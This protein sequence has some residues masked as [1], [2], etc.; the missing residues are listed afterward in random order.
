M[1]RRSS[2]TELR[3]AALLDNAS[4]ELS[5]HCTAC[6]MVQ[7]A[8][9]SR[10]AICGIR[11]HVILP[12]RQERLA[13]SF[14]AK[15]LVEI[16]NVPA[17]RSVTRMSNAQ[18]LKLVQAEA[19]SMPDLVILLH[20]KARRLRKKYPKAGEQVAATADR[21]STILETRGKETSCASRL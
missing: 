9:R 10:C 12:N 20:A 17:N 21:L 13:S 6:G 11:Q 2:K 18:L 19:D 7:S 5:Y 8:E 15:V 3:L 1:L 16:L 4:S 14:N